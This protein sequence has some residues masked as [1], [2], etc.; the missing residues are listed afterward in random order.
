MH[1]ATIL[2]DISAE[3]GIVER[4]SPNFL[5]STTLSL[6]IRAK[7]FE[8]RQTIFMRKLLIFLATTAAVI[9]IFAGGCS[10]AKAAENDPQIPAN[11]PALESRSLAGTSWV[12]EAYGDPTNLTSIIAG[13][14]ITLSF[15]MASNQIS[16]NGGVNGYG[17]E[18]VRTDNQL[19]LSGILHTEMASLNQR[20]NEQEN[21]YFQLLGSSLS[22]EFDN[23][24]LT[25]NCAVGQVLVFNAY[26]AN[27]LTSS[28]TTCLT[29]PIP[30]SPPPTFISPAVSSSAAGVIST[31]ILLPATTAVPPII[32][33]SAT[34]A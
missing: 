18:A 13:S 8:E 20:I 24:V 19:T 14:K 27:I 33:T 16:G 28:P 9:A 32:P 34:P 11:V 5:R 22:A 10:T 15:N 6:S 25:I 21:S 2:L 29:N 7:Q 3:I 1:G 12:L 23:S 31:T 30:V 17:G 26:P 4:V